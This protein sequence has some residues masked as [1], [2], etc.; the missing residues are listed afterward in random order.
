METAGDLLAGQ[1]NL[2]F[3]WSVI[4]NEKKPQ[5]GHLVCGASYGF[6]GSFP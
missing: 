3:N 4:L 5:T 6:S 1:G 2:P